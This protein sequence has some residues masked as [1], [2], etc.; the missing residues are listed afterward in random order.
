MAAAKDN[1]G[2]IKGRRVG[3]KRHAVKMPKK[4]SARDLFAERLRQLAAD[5]TTTELGKMLE[6]DADTVGKWLRAES[7]PDLNLWKKLAAA[8]GLTDYRDLLP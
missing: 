7:L 8:L 4:P 1:R 2:S 3:K 6:V 5:R